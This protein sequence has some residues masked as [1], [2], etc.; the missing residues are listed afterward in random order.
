MHDDYAKAGQRAVFTG[1][2]R[3]DIETPS[4][5]N[6]EGHHAQLTP[7]EARSRTMYPRARRQDSHGRAYESHESDQQKPELQSRGSRSD[8]GVAE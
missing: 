3:F 4:S 2:W 7:G 8:C 5:E 6:R 1:A